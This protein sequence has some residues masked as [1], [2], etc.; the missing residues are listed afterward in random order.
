MTPV[1][2]V[3]S[4]NASQNYLICIDDDN[5]VTCVGIG[6]VLWLVLTTKS[7]LPS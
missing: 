4:F 2:F 5:K 7:L 3:V 1:L 6:R